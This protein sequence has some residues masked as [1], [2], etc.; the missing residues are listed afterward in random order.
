MAAENSHSAIVTKDEILQIQI[1]TIPENTKKATKY[2]LRVFPGN[3]S[4]FKFWMRCEFFVCI[5]NVN[6]FKALVLLFSD[7]L[8]QQKEFKTN[9]EDNYLQ[10]PFSFNKFL[11][12]KIKSKS[13]YC[14]T[15]LN[16]SFNFHFNWI[17]SL[18][19]LPDHYDEY[20]SSY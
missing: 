20:F 2:G 6:S 1:N 18:I 9:I 8:S 12:K 5:Y 16:S 15:F 13:R 10:V 19:S 7:W 4:E 14:S 17:L 3:L 11:F